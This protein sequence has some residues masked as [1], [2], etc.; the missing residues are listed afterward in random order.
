MAI[1]TDDFE[2]HA[3]RVLEPHDRKLLNELLALRA[4]A[5]HDAK[6][7]QPGEPLP[8]AETLNSRNQQFL[9]RAAQLLGSEKF[10][11]IFGFPPYQKLDLV[12]PGMLGG[13]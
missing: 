4:E 9:D 1:L 7:L 11:K 12:D 3:R 5:Q 8:T 13:R 10:V 2:T 6:R